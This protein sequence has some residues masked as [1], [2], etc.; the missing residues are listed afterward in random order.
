[1]RKTLMWSCADGRVCL[2]VARQHGRNGIRPSR[3]WPWQGDRRLHLLSF[4]LHRHRS[5][6]HDF[7]Y[8]RASDFWQWHMDND[9]SGVRRPFARVTLTRR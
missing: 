9:S 2:F 7:V 3:H 6:P 4:Q 1:M 5:L 8:N